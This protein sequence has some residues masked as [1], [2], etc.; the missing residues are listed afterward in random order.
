MGVFCRD[1][2]TGR[3]SFDSLGVSSWASLAQNP[4]CLI[5]IK[6]P[7]GGCPVSPKTMHEGV[8]LKTPKII[9]FIS[10]FIVNQEVNLQ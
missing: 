3:M 8:K 6:E 5:V 7:M 10:L 4:I 1:S 2:S 9:Y